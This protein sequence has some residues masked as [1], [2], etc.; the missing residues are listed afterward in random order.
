MRLFDTPLK[1]ALVVLALLAGPAF[2]AFVGIG[3]SKAFAVINYTEAVQAIDN[4]CGRGLRMAHAAYGENPV[5]DESSGTVTYDLVILWKRCSWGTVGE[6]AITGYDGDACPPIGKYHYDNYT[7]TRDCVKYTNR[8]GTTYG[9]CGVYRCV[10]QSFYDYGIKQGGDGG[11]FDLDL[12]SKKFSG[13]TVTIGDWGNKTKK[14]GTEDVFVSRLGDYYSG[15][16]NRIKQDTYVRVSWTRPWSINGQSY[17]Q[18]GTVANKDLA[19][20]GPVTAKPGDRLNW[21]HDLRNDGPHDMDKNVYWNVDKTGF[22]NGWNDHKEPLGNTSGGA[23]VLFVYEYAQFPAEPWRAASPYTKYDVTQ[24]DVGNT[25]CQRIAWNPGKYDDSNWYA[26]DYA[27]ADVPYNYSLVPT[28]SNVTDGNTVEPG[29]TTIPVTGRVTNNGPTKSQ[30]NVKWQITEVKYAPGATINNKSG[31]ESSSNP[32]AYFTG[33]ACRSLSDGTETSGYTYPDTKP[34]DVNANINDEPV[35]TKMCY[36]MSVQPYTQSSSNWSHSQLYC[37]VVNKRP[38]AD[39]LGGDLIVGRGSVTNSARVSEVTTSVSKTSSN[40]YFGSWAEYGITST[41]IVTGMASGSGFVGG[42]SGSS[43]CGKLSVLTLTN[44]NAAGSCSESAIGKYPT[45]STAPSIA[46]RFPVNSATP[47]LSGVANITGDNLSGLYKAIDAALTVVSDGAIPAGRWV[48]IN[49]PNT[50]VTIGSNITYTSDPLTS[51]AQIPQV[52]IIAKNIIIADKDVGKS[53]DPPISQVDSWLVAVGSGSDG[54]IN[55][56]GAGTVSEST[57]LTSKV[58]D[59][60]LTVNGP[61]TANHLILRRTAGAG[62][63]SNAGDP[64]EV[65]NLRADAYIWATSYSPG[66]GRLPTVMTKEIPPRF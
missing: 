24:D 40:G 52:V 44:A 66:T 57:A 62:T 64:A 61:I 39:V 34:Y 30:T 48:V 31:G 55:T 45:A 49:A 9:L 46:A 58:C 53:G 11:P 38:K 17:I 13:R 10:Y 15:E 36:A 56:C 12:H 29:G 18:N 50:T 23:N 27:C 65:F 4:A 14:S 51:I 37:L 33:G 21:Y 42:S 22:S 19:S 25:L 35:G 54:R 16:S 63:G 20:K 2:M 8:H 5:L 1:K 32:C 59:A 6:Y 26:S 28:I 43:L 47:A 3:G 60:K 41:G 7:E